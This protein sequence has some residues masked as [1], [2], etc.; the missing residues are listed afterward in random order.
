M[1]PIVSRGIAFAVVFGNHD[2]TLA[3]SKSR[4]WDFYQTFPGALGT[5]NQM[6]CRIG[7]YNLVVNDR[8]GNPALNLWFLDS[9]GSN[10]S[11]QG[12]S[13]RGE[14]LAW[15]KGRCDDLA[16]HNGGS[17]VPSVVFQHIPVPEIYGLLDEADASVPGAVLG[18]GDH[19]GRYYVTDESARIDGSLGQGPCVLRRETREFAAWRRQGDVM[20]AVF[21]HDHANDFGGNV[22]GVQLMYGSAAGF[23]CYGNGTHHGVRVLEF[24]EDA[25]RSFETS[26]VYWDDLTSLPIP[27]QLMYDGSFVHHDLKVVRGV[28][29][30]VVAGAI[31]LIAGVAGAAMRRRV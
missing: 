22:Q 3:L 15:Y 5:K 26:L 7:N 24:R 10:F 9:G 1:R 14:Q 6:G 13:M 23:Y 8:S 21:G 12:S 25:V 18:T 4:Q 30:A 19:A 11:S 2:A 16:R 20:A 31:S 28:G 17:V 29:V 27:H